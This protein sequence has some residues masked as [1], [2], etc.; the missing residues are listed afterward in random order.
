MAGRKSKSNR[1]S[2]VKIVARLA[3]IIGRGKQG[4]VLARRYARRG[5]K[6]R[7]G[8]QRPSILSQLPTDS[9][10]RVLYP[11]T[12]SLPLGEANKLVSELRQRA[13][14]GAKKFDIY[15]VGSVA[16]Q[17]PK[18]GDIDLL[19]YVP[20][21]ASSRNVLES[22]RLMSAGRMDRLSLVGAYN[23]GT[24]H[25]SVVVRWK[26]PGKRDRYFHVDLFLT[27]GKELPFALFHRIGPRIYNI[28]I[29]ALAKRKGWLLNQHGLFD[30][31]TGRR[32]KG[33]EKLK[34]EADIQRF[35]GVHTRPPTNR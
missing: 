22:F 28:R 29:R 30:R 34:T 32:V 6:T 4:V 11:P 35:L 26:T 19:V 3:N 21:I 7:A 8:L 23:N 27:I 9:R 10:M 25:K 18:V 5:I 31:K 14:F 20:K 33:S 16:R 13:T 1:K 12:K 2:F 15:P 17:A 24:H